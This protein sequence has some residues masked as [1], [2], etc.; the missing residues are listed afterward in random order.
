MPIIYVPKAIGPESLPGGL[1]KPCQKR[2]FEG[3]SLLVVVV[4]LDGDTALLSDR[5]SSLVNF[6]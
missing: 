6:L 1:E 5:L 4:C 2:T 3:V